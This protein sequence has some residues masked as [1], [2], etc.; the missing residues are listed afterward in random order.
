ML[1]ISTSKPRLMM[2][3]WIV[4]LDL[5]AYL[6]AMQGTILSVFIRG[7]TIV[8]Q[9]QYGY[10]IICGISMYD[11]DT[12]AQDILPKKNFKTHIYSPKSMYEYLHNTWMDFQCK[13]VMC[14]LRIFYLKKFRNT[15]YSHLSPGMDIYI[16]YRLSMY[17]F[18]AITQ[19]IYLIEFQDTVCSPPS[20]GMD[21]YIIHGLSMYD[22]DAL[23]QDILPYKFSK[24]SIYYSKSRYR[25]L[26]NTSTFN[27]KL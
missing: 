12:L 25:Y 3:T 1:R 16:I 27:V 6:T 23:A 13:I 20:P 9:V 2:V 19:D 8:S 4:G 7:I 14:Q 26:Y 22:C 17:D 10:Y 11:C 21:I 18:D 15:I 5:C 24:H